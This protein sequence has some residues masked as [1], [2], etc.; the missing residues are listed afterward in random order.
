MVRNSASDP[1]EQ[2]VLD[3]IAKYGWHC[4]NI[5]EESSYPPFTFTIGLYHTW[6]F[7]ELIVIGF[8]SD[9]AQ[10]VFSSVAD[11]LRAGKPLNLDMP[12]ADLLEGYSCY[13]VEVPKR[14]YREYVGFGRWFY[15]GNSFPLYQLVWPSKTGFFPWDAQS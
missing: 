6:N 11:S 3:N 4:L 12:N 8:K 15:Q 13:F 9:V 5:L 1:A 2:R 10:A 7:P 14:Q